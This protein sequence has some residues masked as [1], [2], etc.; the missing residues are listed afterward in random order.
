MTDSSELVFV[1]LG[2]A[3]EIGMNASL[4]GFGATGR[5]RWLMVDLGITFGGGGI[6]GVDVVMPDPAFIAARRDALEA[7]IL[8]H[9]HEDHLGAVAYLWPQLRCPVYASPFARA[10]LKRKLAE[11]GL[12]GVVPVRPLPTGA[13]LTL[14]PFAIEVIGMTHSIPEPHAV[15]IR[16]PAGIVVHSGDWKLDD[17]PVIGAPADEDALRRIGDEGVLALVCDSTNVFEQGVSGS[18]ASVLEPLT[19]LIAGCPGRVAV[20]CFSTNIARLETIATAAQR[21]GRELVLSGASLGRNVAAAEECG[22][23]AGLPPVFDGE[24]AARLPRGRVLI[25]CTGGQGERNAALSRLAFDEHPT[26]TLEAGDAVIFSSRVIPGNEVAIGRLY[27]QLLRRG[28]RVITGRDAPIHVSGHPARDELARLYAWLRPRVAVPVHGELRHMLEHAALARSLGVD[29]AIVA[30]N[31]SIVRLAPAAGVAGTVP[32]G[33]LAREGRQT[34]AL[35]SPLIR[36]RARALFQGAALVTVVLG[37]AS[38]ARRTRDVQLST[39]GLLE[40]NG[41]DD[42][43]AEAVRAAVRAAIDGLPA[44]AFASDE[45]VCETTRLVVRRAFRH[46]LDKR[47]VTEVHLVRS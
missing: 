33:R 14:G 46:F 3:G 35:D 15:V 12:D 36:N 7:L 42:G 28:I 24:K 1:A 45:R 47:P 26:L 10:I 40:G 34:V 11:T 4:Y 44:R 23:L 22:Y 43:V 9:A 29:A 31:G 20:T 38:A 25:V 30:E 18:E 6:P 13:A 32:T 17:A 21:T 37:P 41:G 2:G 16:T 8:T 39:I 27:N 5:E 19:E